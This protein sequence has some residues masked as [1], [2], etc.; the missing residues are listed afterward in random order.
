LIARQQWLTT[1][2]LSTQEAESRR[3]K[4]QSQPQANSSGEPLE[5]LITKKKELAE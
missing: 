2:V 5:K 4:V 3:V 1:I